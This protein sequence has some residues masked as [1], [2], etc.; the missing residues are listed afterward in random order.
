V[1]LGDADDDR[2]TR[3]DHDTSVS[4]TAPDRQN[5]AISAGE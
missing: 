5:P 4:L 1:G 2:G 3:I